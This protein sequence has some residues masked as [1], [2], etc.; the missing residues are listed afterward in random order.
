MGTVL[1]GNSRVIL[2][3]ISEARAESAL[4]RSARKVPDD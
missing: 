4:M 2:Q 3:H 1:A